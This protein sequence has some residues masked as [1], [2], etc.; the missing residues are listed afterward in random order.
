[1]GVGLQRGAHGER[2]PELGLGD[3]L[4]RWSVRK[5]ASSRARSMRSSKALPL[6][7]STA[8]SRLVPDLG[9]PLRDLERSEWDLH[10]KINTVSAEKMDGKIYSY[11]P[12]LKYEAHMF[13]E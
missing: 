1:M 2:L 5:R 8:P 7:V 9:K 4:G 11:L 6:R 13:I 3:P 12:L 10:L